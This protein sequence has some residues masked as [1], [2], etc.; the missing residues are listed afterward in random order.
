MTN[1][2]E[3]GLQ[4]EGHSPCQRA[5]AQSWENSDVRSVADRRAGLPQLGCTAG[6][7]LRS[8]A[9]AQF[10]DWEHKVRGDLGTT[11][12]FVS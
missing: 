6:Q 3:D 11:R 7:C 10:E 8:R 2:G 4:V 1:P 12:K 5:A 9:K